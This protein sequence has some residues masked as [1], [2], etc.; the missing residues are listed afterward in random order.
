MQLT[1]ADKMKEEGK[2]DALLQ[3]LTSKFGPLPEKTASRI[4]AIESPKKL[5]RYLDRVLV[6]SSLADMG[7][8][9]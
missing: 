8:G 2:K 4:R 3:L 9:D 1:W 7:L 6:A 5:D